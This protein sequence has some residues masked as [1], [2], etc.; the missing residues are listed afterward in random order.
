MDHLLYPFFEPPDKMSSCCQEKNVSCQDE[1]RRVLFQYMSWAFAAEKSMD[2]SI[3]SMGLA[4]LVI[5]LFFQHSAIS[6]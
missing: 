2:H 5:K 3:G 6:K 1:G 4:W